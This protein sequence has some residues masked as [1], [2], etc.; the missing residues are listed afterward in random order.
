MG[1]ESS[2]KIE[3]F[4][5]TNYSKT[6]NSTTNAHIL[7]AELPETERHKWSCYY[8]KKILNAWSLED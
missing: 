2:T 1:V 8:T 3:C 7:K 6:Q 5:E 4:P